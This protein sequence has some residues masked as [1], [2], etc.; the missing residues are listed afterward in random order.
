M[1]DDVGG[2]TPQMK[3]HRVPVGMSPNNDEIRLGFRRRK[4]DLPRIALT[5]R[6]S[7]LNAGPPVRSD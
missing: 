5:C 6:N 7:A 1:L 4:D 2:Y 3:A